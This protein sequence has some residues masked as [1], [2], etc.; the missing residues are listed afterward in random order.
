MLPAD[1][2][3]SVIQRWA[4]SGTSSGESVQNVTS[5]T[6][7]GDSLL[8]LFHVVR[9]ASGVAITEAN[10]LAIATVYRCVALIGGAVAQLPVKEYR[11]QQG[12]ARTPVRSD[13][14]PLLNLSPSAAWTA[15]AWKEWIA[16]TVLLRGDSFARIVWGNAGRVR[17]IEPLTNVRVTRD[18]GDLFYAYTDE[19]GIARGLTSDEVLHFAGFGFDGQK[20]LSVLSYAAR[21]GV[22]NAIAASEYAGRTFRE[23]V[24][25][26]I[27]LT[28]PQK[29]TKEQAQQLR[30]SFANVYGGDAGRRFPLVLGEGGAAHALSLSPEDAQLLETRKFEKGDICTAFGVPPIMIGDTE[31]TSSWGTG[32]EQ[33]AIGFVRYTLKP[34]LV[35]WEEE[36]NRKLFP[37]NSD[38]FVEFEVD[39]LLSGDSKAQTE[40]FKAALGG[41][42]AGPGW[43]TVNEVRAL[44][45]L[46]PVAGGD[47]I[48][49]PR[50]GERETNS[51]A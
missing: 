18:G 11:R 12:G 8:D 39:G 40:H 25:P 9:S 41:P 37:N 23:G 30:E 51:V 3:D 38:R 13:L 35:R 42:G 31:K 34:H 26:Q 6:T 20:S 2:F 19:D 36:I 48:Y 27:A 10:A 44:K 33:I 29:L 4:P 7:G 45:N 17:A 5:Y 47:Q 49:D 43:M 15:A 22:G 16:R 14:W 21:Q 28:F 1:V 32:I 50:D 24:M 46:P